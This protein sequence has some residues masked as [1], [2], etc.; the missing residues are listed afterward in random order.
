MEF[1]NFILTFEVLGN[2]FLF[3]GLAV[4]LIVQATKK[5]VDKFFKKLPFVKKKVSTENYVFLIGAIQTYLV[6]FQYN[7]LGASFLNTWLALINTCALFFACT[8]G[9]DFVCKP[10]T[11][12]KLP[13]DLKD[14]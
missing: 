4:M 9:F 5:M 13:I 12:K 1:D 11:V 10:I 14:K 3:S 7:S 8:K 2:N 6:M